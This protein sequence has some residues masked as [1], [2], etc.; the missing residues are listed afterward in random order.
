[1]SFSTLSTTDNPKNI[2]HPQ[3]PPPQ[4]PTSSSSSSQEYKGW[5]FSTTSTHNAEAPKKRP[6]QQLDHQD[7]KKH[8]TE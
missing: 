3:Q 5:T 6:A 2:D 7:P 8:K 1:M 4:S